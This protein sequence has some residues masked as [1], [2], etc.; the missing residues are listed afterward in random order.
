MQLGWDVFWAKSCCIKSYLNLG[1]YFMPLFDVPNMNPYFVLSKGNNFLHTYSKK[2][3]NFSS[4]SCCE[5]YAPLN[6]GIFFWET[7]HKSTIICSDIVTHH[8]QMHKGQEP[9]LPHIRSS[10]LGLSPQ[11]A[12]CQVCC[13]LEE[14]EAAADRL[15][16]GWSPAGW[17]VE[18]P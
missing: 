12:S 17:E 3:S 13:F 7:K 2:R 9:R 8:T 1:N 10:L 6:H 5:I 14:M 18:V 11:L 16:S 4:S 15:W